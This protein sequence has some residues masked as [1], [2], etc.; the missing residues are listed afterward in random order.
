MSRQVK[1]KG[2]KKTNY[3]TIEAEYYFYDIDGKEVIE[4]EYK[5]LL[6][7]GTVRGITNY[8]NGKKNGQSVMYFVSDGKLTGNLSTLCYYENDKLEGEFIDYDQY[9]NI[10]KICYY[11]NNEL[12]GEYK[13]YHSRSPFELLY[14]HC[15]YKNGKK[16][17]KYIKYH[18]P[19][20]PER[21]IN[22]NIKEIWDYNNGLLGSIKYFNTD[23]KLI[24]IQYYYN[25]CFAFECEI[26]DTRYNFGIDENV[27]DSLNVFFEKFK[28]HI[29][30][31]PIPQKEYITYDTNDNQNDYHSD[32]QSDENHSEN[33]SD[34]NHSENQ[35]DEN[36]SENHSDYQSDY[37]DDENHS[38]YQ[39][40]EDDHSD[41]S[42]YSIGSENN[43]NI[44]GEYKTYYDS[45]KLKH[46]CFYNNGI[47]EGHVCKYHP[48]GVLKQFS[49]Y[50][51]GKLNGE[52]TK[53]YSNGT[54][55]RADN[56]VDGR[57]DGE[58]RIYNSKSQLEERINYVDNMKHG[59]YYKYTSGH[60]EYE[61]KYYY[62]QSKFGDHIGE[63][64]V[65]EYINYYYSE[66]KLIGN[67]KSIYN[68]DEDRLHGEYKEYHIG[69][70]DNNGHIKTLGTYYNGYKYGYESTYD[71]NGELISQIF[72]DETNEEDIEY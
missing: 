57:K 5:H 71:E 60:L 56:F 39:S 43:Y 7:N 63:V 61:C 48:N 37:N 66:N 22:G 17:G 58:T 18:C 67:I 69:T 72:I 64:L 44:N 9:N 35:S 59:K 10:H 50:K 33:Q 8:V 26:K 31:N 40:D 65:G 20:E 13:E 25:N 3:G 34:E 46:V 29:S 30:N 23:G 42:E 68:Y 51:N 54:L 41:D 45:G 21:C 6:D 70:S 11:L 52:S 19:I 36:H 27:E 15:Y 49:I 4:G 1:T 2:H 28:E 12:H 24:Q 55:K 14:I 47:L 16:D 32:Y 53:F 38:D 62:S